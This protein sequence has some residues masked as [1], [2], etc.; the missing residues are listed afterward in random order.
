MFS[1]IVESTGI[2]S[3]LVHENGCRLLTIAPIKM[4]FDVATL[5]NATEHLTDLP[6]VFAS[7]ARL[8]RPGEHLIFSHH[9]WFSWNGHHQEPKTAGRI[10]PDNTE[11]RRFVDAIRS[12]RRI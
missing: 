10:D 8:L 1:G 12:R 7:V 9:N 6:G 4:F 2:I 5:H 11:Q 3:N